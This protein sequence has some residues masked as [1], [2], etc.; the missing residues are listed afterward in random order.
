MRDSAEAP[1][2]TP[3]LGKIAFNALALTCCDGTEVH[4]NLANDSIQ[5]KPGLNPCSI[6]VSI[7]A[8]KQIVCVRVIRR[9]REG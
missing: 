1:T 3:L 5:E 4:K 9:I 8:N 6:T 7:G 2:Q